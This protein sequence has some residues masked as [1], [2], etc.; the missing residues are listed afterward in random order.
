MVMEFTCLGAIMKQVLLKEIFSIFSL[1]VSR[2][3]TD[4][5]SVDAI[6]EYF[7]QCVEQHPAARYIGVF[8]HYEHTR[9][10]PDGQ[11]GDSIHAAKNIIFCFG[12]TLPEPQ[13]MAV[14]PRSIGVVET[15]VGFV[16]SFME[17]PMP[18]A[19]RVMETWTKALRKEDIS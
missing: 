3:E 19:N 13:V 8:D 15:H 14:R 1:E 17:A 9:S 11:I 7:R 4:Y 2:K 18:I 6:I 5:Q 10:L 16:I 12:L